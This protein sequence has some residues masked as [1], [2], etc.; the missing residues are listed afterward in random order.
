MRTRITW[1][2]AWGAWALTGLSLIG[3]IVLLIIAK[4]DEDS[5]L[6]TYVVGPLAVMGIATVG[7]LIVSRRQGNRIGW[8]L[9][10]IAFAYAVAGLAGAY[11][12]Y[13]L[14]EAAGPLPVV[15]LAAWVNRIGAPAVLLPIPLLFLLF[16]DGKVPSRRWR[17]V[18]W[19]LLTAVVVNVATFALTPGDLGSGFTEIKKRVANPVGL[20]LA[21]KHGVEIASTVAGFVVFIGGFA[22]AVAL[23]LRFRRARG[24]E[25][26]QIKWLAFVGATCVAIF[27]IGLLVGLIRVVAGIHVGDNDPVGNVL[28]I[29][30]FVVLMIGIPAA[31][32]IAAFKYRL[33]DLDLVVKKT[34]VFAVLAL[35]ISALYI[36]LLVLLG[37]VVARTREATIAFGVGAIAAFAFQP[38]RR[39]A[40][41]VADRLVYGRRA[42]P[43]EVIAEFSENMAGTY[44]TDDVLPRM[45]QILG[46]G[47]GAERAGV[48]L[49]IGREL[50][51][52]ATWPDGRDGSAPLHLVGEDLP[53]FGGF[54]NAFPVRHQGEL[55]GALT[56]AMPPNDPMNPQKERVAVDLAAQGGLVL[57][58][59]RLIEELRASRQRL[60]AAQDEERR[61]IERNIHDGAQQQL[62]ALSVK[63]RL[64]EQLAEK[65]P[66]RTKQALGQVQ[67]EATEALENLRDLARG[68]YPPL[69]ADK[70]LPE[71]LS[72]QARKS[73]IAVTIEADGI[74][75]YRQEVEA[76]VYFCA[77]EALQ[78]VAKYAGASNA[79]I[80]LA[81][82]PGGLSFEISDDGAGFDPATTPRGS[83]LQNMADRLEAIG[84]RLEIDSQPAH[85]TTVRGSVPARAAEAGS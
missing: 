34:V 61:K 60:V 65:D 40:R 35:F 38:V 36:V 46:Q 54:D 32:G 27:L 78:N 18:L 44:S 47:T 67:A 22:A 83:G 64:A 71:A 5:D 19:L 2:I 42:T 58:N 31:S 81:Q 69:L 57:R 37:G 51:P 50:V 25:R 66:A 48:W 85:G 15:T 41:R 82:E 13:A 28:F 68:I 45:A 43:Y 29:A 1:W 55:L 9:C 26:Q 63:L 75:R 3:V 79:V 11:A 33:Y 21:W 62:V 7:A 73:P 4:T 59:V 49:H 76:A 16:P 23:I 80:R 10:W 84:G 56:L 12:H 72:S 30:F 74:G 14:H 8:I 52:A 53:P 17:P 77:L 70:G 6:F 39:F 20:P 24:D